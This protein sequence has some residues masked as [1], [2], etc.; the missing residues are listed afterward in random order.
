M[1]FQLCFLPDC[2]QLDISVLDLV[3]DLLLQLLS[4]DLLYRGQVGVEYGSIH[5]G[6]RWWRTLESDHSFHLGR[7][8]THY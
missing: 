6:M 2:L 7:V 4:I 8:F 3:A 1:K 5:F